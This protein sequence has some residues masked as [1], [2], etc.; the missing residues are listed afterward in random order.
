MTPERWRQVEEIVHAALS[1]RES[2]RMA[3]LADACAGDEALRREVESLLTQQ[4]SAGGFLEGK[5]VAVAAQMINE[6]ET[7]LLT[8]RRLGAYEVQARIGAGGMGEVYRAR[9]TRLSRDVAIKI[10]PR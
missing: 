2:Q 10:L 7:S 5:A 3:F 4:A 8:G 9:D 6:T 1:R